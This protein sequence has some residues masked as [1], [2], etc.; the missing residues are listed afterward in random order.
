LA[1]V[2]VVEDESALRDV[3]SYNLQRAGH[4][5]LEAGTASEG[6]ALARSARPD[7]VVLDL[8]LPDLPGTEVCKALKADPGLSH[9]RIVM[10]TAR[11]EEVDRIVGFEL[12][13]D[14]YVTKP[15]SVRELVLR[16]GAVLRRGTGSVSTPE[17]RLGPL[18]L[19]VERH[20]VTVDG[21]EIA[22][23]ALE[24]RLLHTLL[25]RQGRVQTRERLLEDVWGMNGD[26]TTRTVDT[27]V[28]RVREKLGE[29]GKL[30]E[31]VRG[32]GYR[33]VESLEAE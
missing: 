16:V 22:L 14:D 24:F 18:A 1:R 25:S 3:V 7:L 6:L 13:A 33:I 12:G 32:V 27:H 20:R 31:T 21:K 17:L 30:I 19:D 23:T 26:I 9:V 28:K 29:A 11:S 2:L 8:M 15:F 10:V 4:E 5:V